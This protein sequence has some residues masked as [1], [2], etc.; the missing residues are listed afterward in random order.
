MI[1]NFQLGQAKSILM[2]VCNDMRTSGK[3]LYSGNDTM[4]HGSQFEIETS[5]SKIRLDYG[6][7]KVFVSIIIIIVVVTIIVII[8]MVQKQFSDIAT[9][10]KAVRR[11]KQEQ[12]V[13]L[14]LHDTHASTSSSSKSSKSLSKNIFSK[15]QQIY[16]PN[17]TKQLKWKEKGARDLDAIFDDWHQMEPVSINPHVL[18]CIAW[19]VLHCIAWDVFYCIACN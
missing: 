4:V 9:E 3:D 6:S 2:C 5:L 8:I 19:V 10:I 1:Y 11:K 15:P 17:I 14:R 13:M 7:A 18:Y 16:F 12:A